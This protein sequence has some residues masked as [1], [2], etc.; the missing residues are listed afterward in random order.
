[1][2]RHIQQGRTQAERRALRRKVGRLKHQKLARGTHKRYCVAALRFLYYFRATRQ[3]D[4]SSFEWLDS[5]LCEFLEQLWAEGGTRNQGNDVCSAITHYLKARRKI[6]GAWE[7]MRTWGK[8]EL[9]QR[10]VPMP[11][12][13]ALGLAGLAFAD[14]KPGLAAA[15]LVGFMG[16]L[17]IEELLWLSPTNLA[18]VSVHTL[19][20]NLGFTKGGSRR[21]AKELVRLTERYLVPLVRRLIHCLDPQLPL[22]GSTNQGFRKKFSDACRRLGL[23]PLNLRPYSMRR[24]G[25]SHHFILHKDIGS[26]LFIGR[27]DSV[28]TGRIYVT[29]GAAELA[30]MHTV[31]PGAKAACK[32]AFDSM[33]HYLG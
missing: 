21:G 9:P 6:P 16:F 3:R 23:T 7:L 17:R 11:P 10:A 31:A 5:L 15:Y 25:A 13:A 29:E 28:K 24:G 2:V 20:C 22:I 8:V 1:M 30:A 12:W 32:A 26:T 19:V 14:Q 33:C 4:S 18:F 27:W